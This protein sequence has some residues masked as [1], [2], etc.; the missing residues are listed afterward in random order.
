M[1][2]MF[3]CIKQDVGG[4]ASVCVHDEIAGRNKMVHN[5]DMNMGGVPCD[6][7]SPLNMLAKQHSRC[8]RLAQGVSGEGYKKEREFVKSKNVKL[9]LEEQVCE[10]SVVICVWEA[11][12]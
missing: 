4:L 1:L 3:I 5:S 8:V 10:Y 9:S 6:N 2:V 12:L 7:F 11:G